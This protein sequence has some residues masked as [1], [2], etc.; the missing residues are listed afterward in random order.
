MPDFVI[1]VENPAVI[2]GAD[3]LFQAIRIRG[4]FDTTG[5][6]V[7]YIPSRCGSV[8]YTDD[9]TALQID[10][11]H[12]SNENFSIHGVGFVD[13]SHYPNGTPNTTHPAIII[14]KGL[15]DG[16][17]IRYITGNSLRNCA[18]HG[19]EK[20]THWIGRALN[21]VPSAA[22]LNYIGPTLFDNVNVENCGTAVHMTDCTL[23]HLW[24]SNS[25]W[26][27]MSGQ[28]IKL[29]KTLTGSG[30]N[31]HVTFNNM[32]FEGIAGLVNTA[33]GLIGTG[34]PGA[35]E[36]RNKLVLNSCN[37]E[38]C[39]LYGPI[40]VG[41]TYQGNPLGSVGNTDI[42]INGIWTTGAAFGEENL[43]G[44][45]HGASITS[46]VRTEFTNDGTGYVFTPEL[47]NVAELASTIPANSNVV[48]SIT[49]SDHPFELELNLTIAGGALG[50]QCVKAYGQAGG[51]KWR[52]VQGVLGTG[53]TVN[54]AD[55]STSDAFELDVING[56][57][58][59][60]SVFFRL[61]NKTANLVTIT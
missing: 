49:A 41:G 3:T 46:T 27:S 54:Y 4:S 6:G 33:D 53:I 20:A 55:G 13:S 39:G 37:R 48:Y 61:T 51:G 17:A 32:V 58:F 36:A 2:D 52:D 8:I 38:F 24:V 10:F 28:A 31:F 57:A 47:V 35:G 50:G 21:E 23:N 34:T 42:Y 15:P 14:S 12:F 5:T 1:K 30:G 45:E 19:Y 18:F 56:N 9:N 22:L 43:P 29:Q 60:V 26:F 7:G 11:S 44:L 40:G 16:S 59:D 25:T